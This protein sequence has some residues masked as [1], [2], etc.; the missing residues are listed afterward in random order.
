MP[1]GAA[2]CNQRARTFLLHIIRTSSH[3]KM[4][5]REYVVIY[6]IAD[7]FRLQFFAGKP[8]K[9]V[10]GIWENLPGIWENLPG[11]IWENQDAV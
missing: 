4:P 8:E 3:A 2:G 11:I 10:P 5:L 1:L 6:L 7:D 9:K